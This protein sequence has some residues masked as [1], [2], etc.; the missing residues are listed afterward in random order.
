[1]SNE[2]SHQEYIAT[3][4]ALID[5]RTCYEARLKD[6]D[7]KYDL[8]AEAVKAT[9]HYAINTLNIHL[10]FAELKFERYAMKQDKHYAKV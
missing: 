7:T 8:I 4:K 3:E 6:Y 1:M 5:L 10:Q 2:L 9:L